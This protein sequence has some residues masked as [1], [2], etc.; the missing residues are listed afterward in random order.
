MLPVPSPLRMQFEAY[1][2]SR[3]VPLA[4][5]GAYGKL[6]RFYLD[7]CLKYHFPEELRGSLSPFLQKLKEKRQTDTQL[8][9]ASRALALYYELLYSEAERTD[10]HLPQALIPVD[11][12]I[13]GSAYAPVLSVQEVNDHQTT[14]IPAVK[15]YGGASQLPVLHANEPAISFETSTS[16]SPSEISRSEPGCEPVSS[17]HSDGKTTGCSWRAIFTR[18]AEEIQVRHYSPKTLKNYT[19]WMRQLQTFT[20]SKDPEL[21]SS[22]DVKEFLTHLAVTT[23]LAGL[24]LFGFPLEACGNDVGSVCRRIEPI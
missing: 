21:L 14:S 8:Q 2:R 1:L 9:Q 12:V 11:E 19:L 3:E 20:R 4:E 18:L 22:I 16:L 6:L 15:T 23:T 24:S 7:F 13:D 5:R 17:S 10:G